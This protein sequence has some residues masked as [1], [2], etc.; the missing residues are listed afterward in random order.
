MII[1]DGTAIGERRLEYAEARAVSL[2]SV[3]LDVGLSVFG[4]GADAWG[5][6]RTLRIARGA[7][8]ADSISDLGGF[9]KLNR[10][11]QRDLMAYVDG[12]V[13]MNP[14]DVAKLSR[15]QK[16]WLVE[17]D[18]DEL[19][20]ISKETR[21]T[22]DVAPNPS[23]PGNTTPSPSP[24]PSAAPTN[25]S[26]AQPKPAP[27]PSRATDAPVAPSSR[28]ASSGSDADEAVPFNGTPPPTTSPA[29]IDG[30]LERELFGPIGERA[31]DA[32]AAYWTPTDTPMKLERSPKMEEAIL[33]AGRS[34]DGVPRLL[35]LLGDDAPAARAIADTPDGQDILDTLD[36]SLNRMINTYGPSTLEHLM[37][38]QLLAVLRDSKVSFRFTRKLNTYGVAYPKNSVG[39]Y[40][41]DFSEENF[42]KQRFFGGKRFHIVAAFGHEGSHIVQFRVRNAGVVMHPGVMEYDAS[43]KQMFFQRAVDKMN[44][45][46][47]MA[48]PQESIRFSLNYAMETQWRSVA[49][50]GH[51]PQFK[52]PDKFY[53]G[54][55]QLNHREVV[56][57]AKVFFP[58]VSEA[59][60][61]DIFIELSQ[62]H[63]RTFAPIAMANAAA[64]TNRLLG[65]VNKSISAAVARR[66][67]LPK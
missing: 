66:I 55:E 22:A 65:T 53:Q 13:A 67:R 2:S 48:T 44:G 7:K 1:R 50:I 25:T 43:L 10:H 18:T 5:H 12:F 36:N 47:V 34:E 4:S 24:S 62:K 61:L 15:Q 11:Q 21:A 27:A 54:I 42:R 41:I 9:A 14:D 19:A 20:R 45:A 8:L 38:R 57:R 58:E 52:T 30:P 33:A 28:V 6:V 32:K 60:I 40:F 49:G 37:A 56:A 39:R 29:T 63:R 35:P 3:M 31:R 46:P 17:A 23:A 16:R 59:E 51:S 64:P 26:A